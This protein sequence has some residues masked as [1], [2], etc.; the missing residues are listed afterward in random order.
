VEPCLK[1]SFH[2]PDDIILGFDSPPRP[3]VFSI[4]ILPSTI[5]AVRSPLTLE[6]RRRAG[7]DD[8]RW[9]AKTVLRLIGILFAFPAMCLLAAAVS[10]TNQNFINTMGNGDWTDGLA[11]APVVLSLLYNP[12]AVV[13]HLIVRKGAALHPAIHLTADLIVWVLAVPAIVFGIAGGMFWN[14]APATPDANGVIDCGFFFNQ[15]AQ[16]CDPMA[17]TIGH[18]EI[19]ALVFLFFLL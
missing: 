8:S 12:A 10:N 4:T 17:Y 11:L 6:A 5:M 2:L 1:E 13:V 19:A 9:R 18:L 7:E 15:W 16:E 3:S 14:W